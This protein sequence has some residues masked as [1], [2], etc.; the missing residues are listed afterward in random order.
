V[1]S[2]AFQPLYPL[3]RSP[4]QPFD[5]RLGRPQNW[6]RRHREEK[7]YFATSTYYEPDEFILVI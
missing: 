7:K 6:S 1:V 2:F 5:R 4:R 3:G